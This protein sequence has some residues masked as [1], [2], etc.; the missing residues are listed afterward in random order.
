MKIKINAKNFELTKAIK[1]VIEDKLSYFDKFGKNNSAIINLEVNKNVHIISVYMMLDEKSIKASAERENL[2]YAI[3][4][5][6]EKIKNH[7]EKTTKHNNKE[8]IRYIE[9][10]EEL[11]ENDIRIVKR[12][13]FDLKPMYEVEAIEQMNL[14]NYDYFIFF[15]ASTEQTEVVYRRK[16]GKYGSIHFNRQPNQFVGQSDDVIKRKTFKIE[17][18]SEEEAIENMNKLGHNFY[19]FL[20]ADTD[21]ICMVYKRKNNGYGIIETIY[22]I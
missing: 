20:N 2:Y 10:K 5:I 3:D 17:P 15:N 21:T 12:K 9:H 22:D 4:D 7:L 19:V 14:L 8:S 11:K 16:D 6:I 13:I 1:E 18:L